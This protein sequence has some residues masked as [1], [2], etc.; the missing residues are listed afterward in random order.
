MTEDRARAYANLMKTL[1]RL[2]SVGGLLPDEADQIRV[3]ADVLLF[4]Q[5]EMPAAES[6]GAVDDALALVEGLVTV[7]RWPGRM[8]RRTLDALAA[9][10]PAAARSVQVPIGRPGQPGN[11]LGRHAA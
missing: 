1:R 2:E 5:P 6:F 10:G 8:A 3:G 7:G 11:Q 9:C 4:S